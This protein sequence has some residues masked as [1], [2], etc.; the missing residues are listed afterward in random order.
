MSVSVIPS[1][2]LGTEAF[3]LYQ[4]LS[5]LDPAT[6][7]TFT[8]TLRLRLGIEGFNSIGSWRYLTR[9]DCVRF[10]VKSMLART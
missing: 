2:W 4:F 6:L 5:A 9:R 10:T 1:L 7:C 8:G 3:Y